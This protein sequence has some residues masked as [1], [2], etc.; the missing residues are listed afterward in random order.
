MALSG[1]AAS[2]EW[3]SLC[4]QEDPNSFSIPS[5]S[6]DV[7]KLA[8]VMRDQRPFYGDSIRPETAKSIAQAIRSFILGEG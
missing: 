3:S 4:T 5:D 1:E 6:L 8:R 7:E 2:P